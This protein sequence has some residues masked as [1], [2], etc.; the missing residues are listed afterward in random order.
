MLE[1]QNQGDDKFIWIGFDD[2]EKRLIDI[3]LFSGSE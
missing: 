1:F 2:E 3:N